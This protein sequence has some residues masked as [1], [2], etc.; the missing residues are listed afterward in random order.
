MTLYLYFGSKKAK[1]DLLEPFDE[2]L[3]EVEV[4]GRAAVEEGVVIYT[5]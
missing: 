1:F 5:S 2:V 4:A 3:D